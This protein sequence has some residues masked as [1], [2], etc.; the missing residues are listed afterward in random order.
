M[1]DS[2]VEFLDEIGLVLNIFVLLFVVLFH[3]VPFQQRQSILGWLDAK[4]SALKGK[5]TA[6]SVK[7]DRQK[8]KKVKPSAPMT[9][10]RRV[11][12][13][14]VIW[15][16]AYFIHLQMTL[17]DSMSWLRYDYDPLNDV[18]GAIYRIE[19]IASWF[20]FIIIC[21]LLMLLIPI[22]LLRRTWMIPLL[23][24]VV[25]ITRMVDSWG[26]NNGWNFNF[27]IL[28]VM[29]VALTNIIMSLRVMFFLPQEKDRSPKALALRRS[30]YFALGATVILSDF[31]VFLVPGFL[32]G[33]ASTWWYVNFMNW[34]VVFHGHNGL[35]LTHVLTSLIMGIISL[36]MIGL[37]A[38]GIYHFVQVRKKKRSFGV[39]GIFSTYYLFMWVLILIRFVANET[40]FAPFQNMSGRPFEAGVYWDGDIVITEEQEARAVLI[41][42]LTRGFTEHLVYPIIALLHAVKFGLIR[43]ETDLEKKALRGLALVL[44]LAMAA[45][46]TEVLQEVLNMVGLPNNDIIFAIICGPVLATGWEKL[47]IEAMLPEKETLGITWT[48]PGNDNVLLWTV[49]LIVG[50]AFLLQFVIGVFSPM[51]FAAM[52]GVFIASVVAIVVVREIP[53]R[54]FA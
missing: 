43:I 51:T 18:S 13:W 39:V 4:F 23:A 42:A 21:T 28:L 8:P 46:F 20:N 19:S 24:V 11:G 45:V 53:R 26:I 27:A 6:S 10:E 30:G 3:V 40:D 44:L 54:V 12:A 31:M 34:T 36:Y 16:L 52:F 38:G 50:G 47:L 41:D 1:S 17:Y 15:L 35:M 29:L 33:Q 7:E 37:A 9:W 48:F 5:I 32:S 25:V 22:P 49:N 2:G 14:L